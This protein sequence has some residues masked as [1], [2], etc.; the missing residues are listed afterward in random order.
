[1]MNLLILSPIRYRVVLEELKQ[2][3]SGRSAKLKCYEDRV[4]QYK[5]NRVLETNQE[6]PLFYFSYC[7]SCITTLIHLQKQFQIVMTENHNSLGQLL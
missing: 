4:K 6:R 7:I 2:R 5:Q 1:M 3:L